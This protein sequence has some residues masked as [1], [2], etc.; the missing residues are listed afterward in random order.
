[1]NI[2][3]I[4]TA[5]AQ[6]ATQIAK[7]V[8]D[9]YRPSPEVG[10]WTHESALVSGPRTNAAMVESAIAARNS[11]LLVGLHD[12]EILACVQIEQHGDVSHI[13]L[14]AVSPAMQG[15]GAGKAMLKHAEDFAIQKYGAN[16]FVLAVVTNRSELAAFYVRRGYRK[17]SAVADYP[18]DAGVGIPLRADLKVE[19]YE[20]SAE[21]LIPV[22]G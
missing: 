8:N 19:T 1:M 18:K 17:T 10:G 7:L 14:L 2:D 15:G 13:G 21:G 12:Q 4:R 3:G 9:A 11:T 22:R 20:K 16:K 5:T 6:D